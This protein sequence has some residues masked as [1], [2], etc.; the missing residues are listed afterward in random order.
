MSIHFDEV[1][2]P[3]SLRRWVALDSLWKIGAREEAQRLADSFVGCQACLRR[4]D[5]AGAPV[6][7]T[8]AYVSQDHGAPGG[9]GISFDWQRDGENGAPTG[10]RELLYI[11][12]EA[13]T[14]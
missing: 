9:I 13:Q 5:G 2:V 3:D 11:P 8:Q 14:A 4:E 7:L 10:F 12:A 1:A 6:T